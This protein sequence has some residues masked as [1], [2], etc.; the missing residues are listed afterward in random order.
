MDKS[1]IPAIPG[2]TTA[3]PN[4]GLPSNYPLQF[5]EITPTVTVMNTSTDAFQAISLVG[6]VPVDAIVVELSMSAQ[7]T[8][9]LGARKTGT[10]LGRFLNIALGAYY[11]ISCRCEGQ[12]VEVYDPLT[13]PA[14]YA[15]TGYWS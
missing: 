10:A 9:K 14:Y 8:N 2:V 4:P 6:I 5:T 3:P 12:T 1:T 15:F 13:G 11:P 7:T